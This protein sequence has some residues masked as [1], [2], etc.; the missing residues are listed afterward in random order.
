MK[1]VQPSPVLRLPAPTFRTHCKPGEVFRFVSPNLPGETLRRPMGILLCVQSAMAV[2]RS[3]PYPLL[4][5]HLESGSV[6]LPSRIDQN[7]EVELLP[8]ATLLCDGTFFSA[9][10]PQ[11]NALCWPPGAKR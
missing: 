11:P 1:I 7:G 3:R 6:Y 4:L 8:N 5:V 9:D 10:L 2:D